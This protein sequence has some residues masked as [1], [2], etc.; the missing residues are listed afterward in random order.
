[1]SEEFVPYHE[2]TDEQLESKIAYAAIYIAQLELQI[3]NQV[4]YQEELLGIIA[5]RNE[6]T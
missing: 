3:R 1:M 2:Y 6:C 4:A 5:M